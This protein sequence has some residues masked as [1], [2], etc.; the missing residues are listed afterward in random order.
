MW[1][2]FASK[3]SELKLAE[4]YF[5]S[6]TGIGEKVNYLVKSA[7]AENV[8]LEAFLGLVPAEFHSTDD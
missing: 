6:C 1:G 8:Q 3:L 4:I 5:R 2:S 7:V